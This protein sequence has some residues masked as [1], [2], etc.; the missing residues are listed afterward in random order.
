MKIEH[1]PRAK[2][3]ISFGGFFMNDQNLPIPESAY[4]GT[5]YIIVKVATA[6]GAIPIENAT[7]I[8][9]GNEDQN[10]AIMLSLLTDRD[11]L[12]LRV[13]LPAPSRV[14]SQAPNPKKP[15]STYNIDVFKEG[16]YPQYYQNVPVFDGIV[17][18]QNANVIPFSK[19]GEKNPYVIEEQIFNEQQNPLL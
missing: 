7:V 18:V 19:N 9:R 11:G 14:D 13:P 8:L 12:T 10:S 6:S 16:F 4:T 15:F 1:T 17:A 3:Y 2:L 5:G